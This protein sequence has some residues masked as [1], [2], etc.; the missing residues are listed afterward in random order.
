MVQQ[1]IRASRFTAFFLDDN[2]SVRSGEIGHSRYI[3]HHAAELGIPVEEIDLNLQFR[4]GGSESYIHWTDGLL[5]FRPGYDLEWRRYGGYD[6][7]L[8]DD[9]P[10]MDRDLRRLAADG[11]TCRIVA[12]YCWRWSKPQG[13]GALVHDVND[14]RFEGWSGPWIAKTGQH[15]KP[16]DHQY[17]QWAT[18][19]EKYEE[20]GSIYSVQGFEFDHVGLIWGEDL[21]WRDGRWVAQLDRNKDHAFKKELRTSGEDPVAKL[22]NVYRVLLTRGMRGTFLFVLDEET[23]AH[24]QACLQEAGALGR[25]SREGAGRA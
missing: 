19:A 3:L 8:V 12:G 7:R 24:V 2:Q 13:N 17:F 25:V 14:P 15:L 23:R 9:V 11:H 18:Q 4:C 10:A 5:G 6:L 20:V 16:L 1:F 21:V 22:R